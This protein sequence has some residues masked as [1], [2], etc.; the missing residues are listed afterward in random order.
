MVGDDETA[1][2]KSG[3]SNLEDG[4]YAKLIDLNKGRNW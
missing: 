3:I 2:T 4:C 1:W